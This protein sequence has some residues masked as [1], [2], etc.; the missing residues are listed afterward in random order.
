MH[1]SSK[2]VIK[3]ALACG[4]ATLALTTSAAYAQETVADAEGGLAEIVVTA[5]K[6]AENLQR[7]PI[8]ITAFSAAELERSGT[9]NV[10]DL[11]TRVPNVFIG[12]GGGAGR[13]AGSFFIRGI[14]VDAETLAKEPG[15]GL[16]IDDIYY[17]K[18]AGALINVFDVESIEVLRGPQGTLFGKNTIGGAI[19]YTTKKPQIG[20]TSG[21]LEFNVGMMERID[22]KAAVNYPLGENAAVRLT[23]AS[24][25]Q[26]GYVRNLSTGS[27]QGDDHIKG[28]RGQFRY[29]GGGWDVNLAVDGL[30]SHNRGE[31]R[32]LERLAQ[33]GSLLQWNNIVRGTAP[34]PVGQTP[35]IYT[36]I[37]DDRYVT[38]PFKTYGTFFGN[39]LN[40]WGATLT[41]AYEVS[42]SLTI[43]SLT[44]YRRVK[45][46]YKSDID[47][48]PFDQSQVGVSGDYPW[49]SQ[50]LQLIGDTFN[51]RLQY[52]L[53]A[54]YFHET[55]RRVEDRQY[56]FEPD[57]NMQ[58]DRVKTTSKALFGQISYAFTDWF[59]LTAGARYSIDE[60]NARTT[61]TRVVLSN[62]TL[63]NAYNAATGANESLN[64]IV[65]LT[66]AGKTSFK[67]FAPRLSAQIQ[68]TRDLMFYGSASKGYRA[69]G[70][71]NGV[72]AASPNFGVLPF[73]NEEV[74]TYEAGFRSELFDR[75]LRV[76]VSAFT[77][78]YKNMQISAS[79]GGVYILI[80]N[81]AK[82]RIRGIEGEASAVLFDGFTV[83]GTL[84]VLDSQ[85]TEIGTATQIVTAI[86]KNSPLAGAPEFTYSLDASYR[87]DLG[88]DATLTFAANWGYK[89]DVSTFTSA[90]TAYLI[91]AYGLLNGSITYA[92]SE[93][94][95]VSLIGK[96]ILDQ[97][98]FLTGTRL[99]LPTGGNGGQVIRSVGR[100]AEVYLSLKV[101]L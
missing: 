87:A 93:Q 3:G 65:P 41:A 56:H 39:T 42:D 14:G 44:A 62:A 33:I 83:G 9:T 66:G 26:E 28:L 43:K 16:Y 94:I 29:E 68:A 23:A 70:F 22:A 25:N 20:E 69:G 52:I 60:K 40:S 27:W 63:L 101:R 48:T 80:A 55:P 74:W 24:L 76:N 64:A 57:G 2:N 79:Q 78:D 45:M 99:D 46:S 58:Y 82:A 36:G 72:N 90:A 100:P 98:Y 77:S 10:L 51:D 49:F 95:S 91:P 35:T 86:N 97:T 88:N 47:G 11:N 89:S 96:N 37:I 38:G 67:D 4:V 75:R 5:Q 85:Y 61:R 21:E 73:E 19:R 12:G 81:V 6:R 84:G 1:I 15:V 7:T 92:P 54:Y 30:W 18:A 50:E 53:G 59:K 17:G 71:N 34:V 31:P 32:S 8:A 13:A